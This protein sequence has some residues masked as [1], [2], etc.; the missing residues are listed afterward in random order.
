MAPVPYGGPAV[1]VGPDERHWRGSVP[2][3]HGG[4]S[5]GDPLHQAVKMGEIGGGGGGAL[6]AR[7]LCLARSVSFLSG[8]K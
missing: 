3:G 7:H 5:A 4:C 8:A 1:R 6:P 2:C